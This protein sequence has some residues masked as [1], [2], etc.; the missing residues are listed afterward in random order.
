MTPRYQWLCTAHQQANRHATWLLLIGLVAVGAW[1]WRLWQR[2]RDQA[3]RARSRIPPLPKLSRTPKVSVLVAAWN[4]HHRI[5]AHLRSFLGLSYPSIE[6]VLCAGGPDGTLEIARR[7]VSERVVV[8]EQQ[9]GEGKQRSLARCLEHASGEII[10]LTDADCIHT[11]QALMRLLAP[12]I[13]E[14]E[15]VATGGTCPLDEQMGKVLPR[16]LWASD[17]VA[18]LRS[19]TYGRG[20]RGANTALTRQALD[21]SGGMDFV[22]PTGTDYQ[23]ALRLLASGIA[24]RQV[25]TSVVPAEYGETLSVYRRR[26]SRWLRNLLIYGHRHGARDDVLVTLKT[27]GVGTMMVLMPL[28]AV[29]GGRSVLVPWL[30]L[31]QHAASAKLRYVFFTAR[32]SQQP[33]PLR[34]LLSIV[35]LTLIDFGVWASTLFDLLKTS[36][37]YQW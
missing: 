7:Y 19:A 12:L 21:R 28:A 30:L 18:G 33:V 8:L 1:N 36:R 26:Q 27:V 2:D 6:L 15:H 31:V 11:D 5:E 24:I 3:D 37:R 29:V 16:Y 13:E 35:P 34:L 4:E 23:L 25:P 32:F 9:P 22:A 17:T 14:G 10:Y 20:L